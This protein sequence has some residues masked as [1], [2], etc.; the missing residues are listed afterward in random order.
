MINIYSFLSYIKIILYIYSHSEN[1]RLH[2]KQK[3]ICFNDDPTTLGL[4]KLINKKY[5]FSVYE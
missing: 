3:L 2:I 5:I 1:I 4:K